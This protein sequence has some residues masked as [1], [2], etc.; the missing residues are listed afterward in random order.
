MVLTHLHKGRA[1]GWGVMKVLK[2]GNANTRAVTG[3]DDSALRGGPS[4]GH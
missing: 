1:G 2:G 4:C 3:S